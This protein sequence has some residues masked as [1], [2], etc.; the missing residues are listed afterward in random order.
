MSAFLQSLSVIFTALQLISP[1][2]AVECGV[3]RPALLDVVNGATARPHE[4]PWEVSF[5]VNVPRLQPSKR[6]FCGG[7]LLNEQWI[8]TAAHCTKQP[9]LHQARW[10][11]VMGKHNLDIYEEGEITMEVSDVFNH[12]NY[13]PKTNDFDFSLVKLSENLNFTEYPHIAPICLPT[14]KDFATFDNLICSACG[15][16]RTSLEHSSG[17]QTL[18]KIPMEIF[19][20]LP[21]RKRMALLEVNLTR[22]MLCGISPARTDLCYGDS[23]GALQ[24]L[25]G[26]RYFLVG[27]A[28]LA[29]CAQVRLPSIYGRVSEIRDWIDE[30]Q[31]DDA[32]S[33]DVKN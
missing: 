13:D 8:L 19:P 6:H 28:S 1:S 31:T 17:A 21:C 29:S 10:E 7:S 23:G 11:V 33:T 3:S 14:R 20:Y 2:T 25:Q 16:G 4:F 12:P 27:D 32:A 9:R 15:W 24:C 18:R 30:V 22:T 5:Q 26:N